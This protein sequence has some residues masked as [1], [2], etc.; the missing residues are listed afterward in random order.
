MTRVCGR[1][2]KTVCQVVLWAPEP[3]TLVGL[4]QSV[5]MQLV[6]RLISRWVWSA[7]AAK[8]PCDWWMF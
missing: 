1:Q 6:A 4:L 3:D 2:S 8:A 5:G 7:E